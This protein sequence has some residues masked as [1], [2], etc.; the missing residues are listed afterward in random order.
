MSKIARISLLMA[1]FIFMQGC[2]TYRF[3]PSHGGGKRFDEEER[4]VSAA[5]RNTIAQVDITYLAGHKTNVTIV[6]MAQNGGGSVMMPGFNS[7]SL[8]YSHNEQNYGNRPPP[9]VANWVVDSTSNNYGANVGYNPNITAWP[10]VFPTDQD[11]AY[12]EASLQMR[13]RVNGIAVTVPDP[14]YILYILVDVLGTNRSKQD[15]LIAWRD[16]L[17]ASCELTYYIV[18]LKTNKIVSGAKRASAEASYSEASIFG[19]AGYEAQRAQCQTSPNPMPTDG[20]DKVIISYKTT[21]IMTPQ[22]GFKGEPKYTDPLA[23]QLQEADAQVNAGNWQV[24]ERLLLEIRAE[25]PNYP[26]LAALASRVEIE[27]AKV[28]AEIEKAKAKVS[29]PAPVSTPAPAVVAPAA[30]P[31]APTPAPVAPAPTT[32]P[33]TPVPAATPS[34]ATPTPVP[35]PTPAPAASAPV[36][37]PASTPAPTPTPAPSPDPN[38]V[39][40]SEPNSTPV[41]AQN[42]APSPEPNAAP[43]A[44]PTAQ[45]H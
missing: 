28:Q 7:A 10:T 23:T 19:M 5:I 36:P 26:G 43:P 35:V 12:L 17:I 22:K 38:T 6:T 13:L 14:E 18:D 37:T 27:K 24:A 11:L 4:A 1:L 45:A 15:S 8:N 25:N 2:N 42:P 3:M 40:K 34:P 30:V 9:N 39:S 32:T 31:A 44:K 41:P 20:N 29:V 21:K 33:A 16:V